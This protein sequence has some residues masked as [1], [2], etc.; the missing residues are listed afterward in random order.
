MASGQELFLTFDVFMSLLDWFGVV[1]FAITG[2]LIASRKQMALI[3][4]ALL[5]VVTGI[6]GS[7]IH[8]LLLRIGPIF[9]VEDP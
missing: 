7:T 6:G 2:A 1:V 9:W 4:F 8:D 5:G 3:G